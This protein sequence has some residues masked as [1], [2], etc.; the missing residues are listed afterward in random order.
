MGEPS[1]CYCP[2]PSMLTMSRTSICMVTRSHL[3]SVEGW[4][5]EPLEHTN[6][7]KAPILQRSGKEPTGQYRKHEGSGFNPW[8]RKNPLEE[9]IATQSVFLPGESH[10]Q[11]SL[12]GY[13][14]WGCKELDPAE[15]TEH[16]CRTVEE[17]SEDITRRIPEDLA[18]S[19]PIGSAK[20]P[21]LNFTILVRFF[22]C[23]LLIALL[24]RVPHCG[25]KLVS[26]LA[27]LL[28]VAQK[29]NWALLWVMMMSSGQDCGDVL[30]G[31]SLGRSKYS[32]QRTLCI[33]FTC[34]LLKIQIPGLY[35]K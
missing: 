25:L 12:V 23:C 15:A 1:A 10:G 28:P 22:S 14:P 7:P 29:E 6:P 18:R 19:E 9:G 11:R 31:I 27:G 24:L 2:L 16:S 33:I 21:N 34:L 5:L 17:I 26:V 4:N 13:S 35:H 32:G 30:P 8:I 3:A 20:L